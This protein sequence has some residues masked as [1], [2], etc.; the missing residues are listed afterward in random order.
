M[1]AFGSTLGVILNESR[2]GSDKV[3]K[4]QAIFNGSH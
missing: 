1:K 2:Y 4:M 3:M